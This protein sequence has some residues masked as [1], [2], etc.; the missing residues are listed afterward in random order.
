MLHANTFTDT[1][2]QHVTKVWHLK[3]EII[4][5][6]F[7]PYTLFSHSSWLL[8]LAADFKTTLTTSCDAALFDMRP[9]CWRALGASVTL[10]NWR[11]F[12][13]LHS[14]SLAHQIKRTLP[15]WLTPDWFRWVPPPT[16]CLSSKHI[17]LSGSP[18]WLDNINT[19]KSQCVVTGGQWSVAHC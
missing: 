16:S 3:A 18:S 8:L 5:N 14:C 7:N 10:V 1:A 2:R 11:L 6:I 19:K 4:H 13:L 15:P 9:V 17:S 12:I